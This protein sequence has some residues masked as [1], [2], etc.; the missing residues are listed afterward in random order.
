MQVTFFLQITLQCSECI[1]NSLTALTCSPNHHLRSC[2]PDGVLWTDSIFDSLP[3]WLRYH[4]NIL[5]RRLRVAVC[6]TLQIRIRTTLNFNN[7]WCWLIFTKLLV[8]SFTPSPVTSSIV[9]KIFPASLH[10][11]LSKYLWEIYN[12]MVCPTFISE[13]LEQYSK[14]N[15]IHSFLITLKSVQSSWNWSRFMYSLL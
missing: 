7:I 2:H 11:K 4:S 10:H 3:D 12:Y 13:I 15:T 6:K 9:F 5:R 14:C 8:V 1:H